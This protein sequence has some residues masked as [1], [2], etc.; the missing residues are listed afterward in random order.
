MLTSLLQ[1]IAIVKPSQRSLIDQHIILVVADNDTFWATR[2]S[3]Y[4]RV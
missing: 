4:L 1:L 2:R 3:L